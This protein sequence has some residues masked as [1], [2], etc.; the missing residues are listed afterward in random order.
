MPIDYR[1]FAPASARFRYCPLC[2]GELTDHPD[3]VSDRLRPTCPDC[4]WIYYPATLTGGLVVAESDAHVLLIRPPGATGS[5]FGLP[6][7]IA[8][9][10]ETPEECVVRETREETG[11]IITDPVELC[12]FL[13]HGEFGPMLHFGFRAR[14][15][16]GT[17]REGDEGPAVLVDRSSLPAMA[18]NRDG[19]RRVFDA[20]L[21]ART[22]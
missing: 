19:S 14:I 3:D 9:Y 6:G 18:G 13:V 12:R 11:L 7:G 16:G 1:R 20:Y 21:A 4:G 8:E 2:T 10:G 15:A 5:G 22:A 17:L